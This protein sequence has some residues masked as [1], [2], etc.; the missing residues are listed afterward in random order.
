MTCTAPDCDREARRGGLC[1]GHHQRKMRGQPVDT[2]LRPWGRPHQAVRRAALAL[3]DVGTA[4]DD[5]AEYF[6]AEA[7]LRMAA[8]RVSRRKA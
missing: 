1:N 5:D 3:G 6:R 2:P 8:L 7:R 4:V